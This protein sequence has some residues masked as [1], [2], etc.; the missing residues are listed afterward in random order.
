MKS[1]GLLEEIKRPFN[2]G[3]IEGSIFGPT[4]F[5]LYIYDLPDVVI[6]DIAVCADATTLYSVI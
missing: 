5:L 2:D 4:P 3:V 1:R 6:S